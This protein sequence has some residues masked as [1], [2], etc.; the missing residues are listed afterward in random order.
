MKIIDPII[1]TI[2]DTDVYKFYIQQ[3]IFHRY[4]NVRV[5]AEFYCRS[6][7]FIG[8]YIKEIYQEIKMME[9]LYLKNE[10]LNYISKFNCFKK[11]YK[12]WLK[13]FRYNPKLIKIYNYNNQLKISIKGLWLEVVMWETP[14]LA[15]ISEIVHRNRSPKILPN[16]AIIFLQEKL[17]NFYKK[18]K[19][20]DM[21]RF[22]LIEFGTRRRFSKKVQELIILT[23]KKSFPWFIGTSNYH[24]AR[25]FNLPPIGTNSHE[26]F[27]AHQ[28]ISPI[29]ANS[30][31]VA[32]Q[33]WLEEYYNQYSI[34]LTDCINMDAFLK[35]FG[36]KFACQYNGLRHDSGDPLKW[37]E[38]AILHYKKLGI[39]PKNKTLIFSDNLTLDKTL[40]IYK[41]FGHLTNVIFGIGT[42]LSCDIP[43]INPLNIIIKL[44][45][46]NGKPVAKISDSPG[47]TICKDQS[48][49]Q[50]LH[51]AYNL[52]IIN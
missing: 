24:F 38:K 8:C 3:A 6:K 43:N 1:K 19:K 25:K 48:F 10:E 35:D 23:L 27:Q 4:Y 51:K 34:A 14:L 45:E 36:K 26:W 40:N 37:G 17:Y 46:C 31:R 52:P 22:K 50:T 39:N 9:F 7:D 49:I 2:L 21:S 33:V 32:L 13:K 18:T 42:H 28:Q 41:K 11:D 20:L 5:K 47:K 44:I 12:N 29:L 15:V 30:Q 16:K